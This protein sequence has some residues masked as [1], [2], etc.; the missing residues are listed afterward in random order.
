MDL[1]MWDGWRILAFLTYVRRQWRGGRGAWTQS[2]LSTKLS[3]VGRGGKRQKNVF[4]QTNH[5]GM[6]PGPRAAK[7]PSIAGR[8]AD[9]APGPRSPVDRGDLSKT[10]MT[11]GPRCHGR[12]VRE[13]RCRNH[14]L[15]VTAI[16]IA[17]IFWN[18]GHDPC[19]GV[20]AAIGT[21][22]VC[23]FEWSTVF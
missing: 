10:K 14:V 9:R 11:V 4:C 16:L 13:P 17:I 3:A 18:N 7:G 2:V 1:L 19:G 23:A 6:T 5:G 22:V 15:S 20:H 8:Q 21:R 12:P